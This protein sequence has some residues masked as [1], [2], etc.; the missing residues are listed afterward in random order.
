MWLIK[1]KSQKCV[2][3][4]DEEEVVEEVSCIEKGKICS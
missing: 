4:G 1:K 3:G 2:F